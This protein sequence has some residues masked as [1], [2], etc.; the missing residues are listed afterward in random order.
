MVGVHSC[1]LACEKRS[2][3][4]K[5]VENLQE[6]GFIALAKGREGYSHERKEGDCATASI[7]TTFSLTTL[8]IM[9]CNIITLSTMTFTIEIGK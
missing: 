8:S 9:T 2:S 3:L 6:K 5:N 1:S 7:I 4:L